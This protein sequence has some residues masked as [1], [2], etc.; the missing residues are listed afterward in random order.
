MAIVERALEKLPERCRIIFVMKRF[1]G[2]TNKEIAEFLNISIKTVEAQMTIAIK[3]MT[4]YVSVQWGAGVVVLLCIWL[5]N[6][7]K[8]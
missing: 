4:S 6:E 1:D 8:E 3:K 7:L 2:K 5:R